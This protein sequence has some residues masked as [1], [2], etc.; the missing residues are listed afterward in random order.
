MQE[1]EAFKKNPPNLAKY[2]QNFCILLQEV[3][4][5]SPQLLTDDERKFFGILSSDQHI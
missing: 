5:S 2:Q 4:N 3:L 1:A